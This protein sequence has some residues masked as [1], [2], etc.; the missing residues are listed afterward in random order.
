MTEAGPGVPCVL[1]DAREGWLAVPQASLLSVRL[2]KVARVGNLGPRLSRSEGEAGSGLGEVR[3][4]PESGLHVRETAPKGVRTQKELAEK[5][6]G[7]EAG[8]ASSFPGQLLCV[9]PRDTVGQ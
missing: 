8:L 4:F 2:G 9:C 7:K 5:K 6:G 3:T 1:G